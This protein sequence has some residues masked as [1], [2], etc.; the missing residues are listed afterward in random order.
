MPAG[1]RSKAGPL[2]HI[3]YAPLP[4]VLIDRKSP[5]GIISSYGVSCGKSLKPVLLTGL[6]GGPNPSFSRTWSFYHVLCFVPLKLDTY[7]MLFLTFLLTAFWFIYSVIFLVLCVC[8]F[9][10]F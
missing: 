8:C 2:G 7:E 10:L 4:C 1:A 5:L 9:V 6:L 3:V